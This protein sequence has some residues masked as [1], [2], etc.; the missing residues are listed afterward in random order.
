MKISNIVI[1]IIFFILVVILAIISTLPPAK[2]GGN[3]HTD[4]FPNYVLSEGQDYD[5]FEI[6]PGEVSKYSS[7]MPWHIPDLN[8]ALKAATLKAGV[9]DHSVILDAT[10]HIGADSVNFLKLYPHARVVSVELN[11]EVGKVLKRNMK[12]FVAHLNLN[13]K[14]S[15]VIVGDARD[16]IIK[17]DIVYF[18]PPWLGSRDIPKLGDENLSKYVRL[19]ADKGAKVVF[20]KLP[21]EADCDNFI[22]E[23]NLQAD[24]YKINNSKTNKLSYWLIAFYS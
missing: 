16:N 15:K 21:R 6:M 7:L 9:K 22:S 4:R 17:A 24:L 13:S 19:A 23:V 11:P 8:A 14:Q 20:V 2:L 3:D 18:D 10:A 12:R 5:M 1:F